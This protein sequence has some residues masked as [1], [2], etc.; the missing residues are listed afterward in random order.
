L[1]KT[2]FNQKAWEEAWVKRS[3]VSSIE[4]YADAVSTAVRLVNEN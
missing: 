1:F 2:N 3:G 4:P